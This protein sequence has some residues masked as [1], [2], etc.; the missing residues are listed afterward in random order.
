MKP[1]LAELKRRNVYKVAVAYAVVAWLLIQAASIVFPTFDAPGWV[2]KVVVVVIAIGFPLAL[3]MAWAFE[4]TPQGIKRTEEVPR[5]QSIARSTGR[6]LDFAI[7]TVLTLAVG[8]LLFDRFRSKPQTHES[9]KTAKSIAVLP[10]ENASNDPNAEYLSEGISEA[11]INSLTEVQQLRV[12]ARTTA[13]HYK[14]TD[15]D[16]RRVGRELQVAAVLT[17]KVRQ[18][19]DALSVQV[20]LVDATTGAQLWGEGYD[21]K[22]SDVI[23]VKQAIAQEVTEKLKL[24][25]SG[26][27]QR[28]LVKR[29]TTNAEAYQFY[30]RGR[31]FWN[32][33]T[34]DGIKQALAQFQQAIARDPNFALGYSGLA[35]AYLL[36]EQYVGVPWSEVMPKAR[37]AADRALQIDDSLAEA[38]TSS[39]VTY[40]FNWQWTEVEP[41]FRRAIALNPNY[42]TAHHWFSLYFNVKGQL[43][44]A[45]R[46]IK[47]AQEL[48]PLSPIISTN[49]AIVLLRKNEIDAAIEECQRIIEFDPNHPSGYDWL[50]QAYFKQ[51]RLAE[52]IV[53]REKAVELSHRSSPQLSLLACLYAITGR[54]TE[55]VGILNEL[56][57][58]YRR[59]EAIG[60]HL[61]AIYY[62]L[63]DEDQGYAWLEK[64]FEQHSGELPFM[65]TR[66]QF[67]H[68]RRNPRVADLVRRMGLNP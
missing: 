21:R 47:R 67:E 54:R 6:K 55:A 3:I 14:G 23:A 43:D 1:L 50:G 34:P 63:G 56:E 2:M 52:A 26:E 30:L 5:E 20:D 36:L 28:R 35:D 24:K 57:D 12:I 62:G 13:F 40:Q 41:E 15:V 45:L 22:I 16:P 61:A 66:P 68:L 60:Q 9:G 64:D 29:D 11:L 32:K 39:A 4:L 42:P 48:D 10:F 27:E 59:H 18:M 51:G 44:D 19:Q 37:A 8:L 33:R 7:I 65:L 46:E 25:L 38:H 53:Q 49:V 31:Y 58:S 17:G